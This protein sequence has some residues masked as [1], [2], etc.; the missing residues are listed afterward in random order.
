MWR[1]SQWLWGKWEFLIIYLFKN[2]CIVSR[3]LLTEHTLEMGVLPSQQWSSRLHLNKVPKVFPEGGSREPIHLQK[4]WLQRSTDKGGTAKP[5]FCSWGCWLWGLQEMDFLM[6]SSPYCFG[7]DAPNPSEETF[8]VEH[9][10]VE[11]GLL[12]F[13]EHIL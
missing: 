8:W 12:L 6:L 3:I 11:E 1:W 7:P 5:A 13:T 2:E 9:T 4:L 10:Q